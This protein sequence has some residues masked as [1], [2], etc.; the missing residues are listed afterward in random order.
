MEQ[1]VKFKGILKDF[2]FKGVNRELIDYLVNIGVYSPDDD[3]ELASYGNSMV[4]EDMLRLDGIAYFL[5]RPFL[6]EIYNELECFVA[7]SAVDI[8]ID[9]Q[10][11]IELSIN[12]HIDKPKKRRAI[13][14]K[15]KELFKKLNIDNEYY[16]YEIDSE[17]IG[18]SKWKERICELDATIPEL[19]LNHLLN[20]DY[21]LAQMDEFKGLGFKYPVLALNLNRWS[22]YFIFKSVS[23]YLNDELAKIDILENTGGKSID[24]KIKELENSNQLDAKNVK[25]ANLKILFE[26]AGQKEVYK[27]VIKDLI[28]RN[29][30]KKTEDSY[31]VVIP[32]KY[33]IRGGQSF[34]CSIGMQLY[35]KGYIQKCHDGEKITEALNNTFINSSVSRKN[36][37][38]LKESP[39]QS[40]YLHLTNFIPYN[41]SIV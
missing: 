14:K 1:K 22:A 11:E 38:S 23:K 35:N 2:E 6:E 28:D 10:K 13:K 33:Q 37:F 36:Y 31:E 24:V 15:H 16:Y 7:D 12:R 9:L 32:T 18:W 3:F 26:E 4:L 27:N 29:I 39:R 8:I 20:E 19:V 17:L 41:R 25:K 21:Y 34:I 5:N 30:I 40:E